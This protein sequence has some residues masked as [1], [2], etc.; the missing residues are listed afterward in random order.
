MFDSLIARGPVA[1]MV[2]SCFL[3]FD[4]R[5]SSSEILTLE[6]E[7]NQTKTSKAGGFLVGAPERVGAVGRLDK[8]TTGLIVPWR[9][10]L[11]LWFFS[12]HPFCDK[13]ASRSAPVGDIFKLP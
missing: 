11:S 3:T 4:V 8:E 6:M 9:V 5:L 12:S 2:S 10:L 7:K 1:L 13:Q